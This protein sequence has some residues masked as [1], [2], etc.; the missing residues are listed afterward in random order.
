[1][2]RQT[3]RG[4]MGFPQWCVGFV[5]FL[6]EY[7]LIKRI[8][9]GGDTKSVGAGR[10]LPRGVRPIPRR[11]TLHSV[12][13]QLLWAQPAAHYLFLP[14]DLVHLAGISY[15]WGDIVKTTR[16]CSFFVSC[17]ISRS[18]VDCDNRTLVFILCV[19]FCIRSPLDHEHP[20]VFFT[21]TAFVLRGKI[22]VVSCSGGPSAVCIVRSLFCA[23]CVL[24][25][26]L[27]AQNER[28]QP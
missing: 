15:D 17:Y 20:F 12:W 28:G 1:M 24:C 11:A 16:A 19:K 4:S 18:D 22:G 5:P 21:R 7:K 26:F 27:R 8:A 3:L 9:I 23:S 6:N 13:F 25:S 10:V 14:S 2:W